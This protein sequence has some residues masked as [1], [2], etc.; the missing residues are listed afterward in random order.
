[1]SDVENV[2][3]NILK[4]QTSQ[5]I[6]LFYFHIFFV[7]RCLTSE[8]VYMCFVFLN[9]TRLG[10]HSHYIPTVRSLRNTDE[11]QHQV[12]STPCCARLKA[13]KTRVPGPAVA[14]LKSV[15]KQTPWVGLHIFWVINT[16]FVA[17]LIRLLKKII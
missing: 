14:Q 15:T 4:G 3:R 5:K 1:M 7:R 6:C 16:Y 12:N 8:I 13:D 10:N 11:R 9:V 2:L 17:I